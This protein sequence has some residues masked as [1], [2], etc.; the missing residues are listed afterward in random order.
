MATRGNIEGRD[1][2]SRDRVPPR[3]AW[4]YAG[5]GRPSRWAAGER[6]WRR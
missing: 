2:R 5:P 6:G 4:R 3:G 1:G